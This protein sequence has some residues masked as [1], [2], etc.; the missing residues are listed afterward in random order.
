MSIALLLG[1]NKVEFFKVSRISLALFPIISFSVENFSTRI[2]ESRAVDDRRPEC[3]LSFSAF[4]III[5]WRRVFWKP[6]YTIPIASTIPTALGNAISLH[7]VDLAVS[8]PNVTWNDLIG[9]SPD[10]KSQKNNF[11]DDLDKPADIFILIKRHLFRSSTPSS[12]HAA[13][14]ELDADYPSGAS[15]HARSLEQLILYQ[16]SIQFTNL[17]FCFILPEQHDECIDA[18]IERLTIAF[19]SG[20]QSGRA[21]ADAERRH[22]FGPSVRTDTCFSYG[23]VLVKA[24]IQQGKLTVSHAG[25]LAVVST[26]QSLHA[27]MDLQIPT[28]LQDITLYTPMPDSADDNLSSP[29]TSPTAGCLSELLPIETHVYVKPFLAFY[30]GYNKADDDGTEL[31]ISSG[32]DAVGKMQSMWMYISSMRVYMIEKSLCEQQCIVEVHGMEFGIETHRGSE[33]KTSSRSS[34]QKTMT[35][36]IDIV[37]WPLHC[38]PSPSRSRRLSSDGN[39]ESGEASSGAFRAVE[40]AHVEQIVFQKHLQL[41]QDDNFIDTERQE[42]SIHK[43]NFQSCSQTLLQ[44]LCVSQ[45]LANCLPNSRFAHSKHS[46]MLVSIQT[47]IFSTMSKDDAAG[48]DKHMVVLLTGMS[49]LK[50]SEPFSED[51]DVTIESELLEI[52][53]HVDIARLQQ[54]HGISLQSKYPLEDGSGERCG[55]AIRLDQFSLHLLL[56]KALAMKKMTCADFKIDYINLSLRHDIIRSGSVKEPGGAS[57][58][59]ELSTGFNQ[60]KSLAATVVLGKRLRGIS[61]CGSVD[62]RWC[63]NRFNLMR[64]DGMKIEWPEVAKWRGPAGATLARSDNGSIMSVE[65]NSVVLNTST[66]GVVR[67]LAS[68]N[69]IT[70]VQEGMTALMARM[71][72][73]NTTA[74]DAEPVS[75]GTSVRIKKFETLYYV[76]T[77]MDDTEEEANNRSAKE[78][79]TASPAAPLPSNPTPA[80]RDSSANPQTVLH[81]LESVPHPLTSLKKQSYLASSGNYRLKVSHINATELFDTGNS[82]D[83]QDP[84]LKITVMLVTPANQKNPNSAT[85]KNVSNSSK[86]RDGVGAHSQVVDVLK[87]ERVVDAGTACSFKENFVVNILPKTT[88][89]AANS[90]MNDHEAL[91]SRKRPASFFGLLSPAVEAAQP[92]ADVEEIHLVIEARNEGWGKQIPIGYGLVRLAQGVDVDSSTTA[93]KGSVTL[94]SLTP[95]HPVKV[96]MNLFSKQPNEK[97]ARSTWGVLRGEVTMTLELSSDEVERRIDEVLSDEIVREMEEVHEP[98][99]EESESNESEG[100]KPDEQQGAQTLSNHQALVASFA[101]FHYFST[102]LVSSTRVLDES[103]KQSTLLQQ[104]SGFEWTK[105]SFSLDPKCTLK[106]TFVTLEDFSYVMSHYIS[107]L[108]CPAPSSGQQSTAARASSLPLERSVQL[109]GDSLSIS[110]SSLHIDISSHLRIGTAIRSLLNQNSAMLAAMNPKGN[111]TEQPALEQKQRY[112]GTIAIKSFAITSD[113]GIAGAGFGGIAPNQAFFSMQL[114]DISGSLDSRDEYSAAAAEIGIIDLG[115]GPAVASKIRSDASFDSADQLISYTSIMGGTAEAAFKSMT[116]EFAPLKEPFLRIVDGAISGPVYIAACGNPG[117]RTVSQ[118]FPLSESWIPTDSSAAEPP[119]YSF[120]ATVK[121][122]I[123]P[124]KVYAEVILSIESMNISTDSALSACLTAIQPALDAAQLPSPPTQI[125]QLNYWDNLRYW[126]HG[127]LVMTVSLLTVEARREFMPSIA[128]AE[129]RMHAP[130]EE[131][132]RRKRWTQKVTSSHNINRLAIPFN[133]LDRSASSRSDKGGA[134]P[135]DAAD[136]KTEVLLTLSLENTQFC[137]DNKHVEFCTSSITLDCLVDHLM[138]SEAPGAAGSTAYSSAP[139]IELEFKTETYSNP[140][141]STP[142]TAFNTQAQGISSGPKPAVRYQSARSRLFSLADMVYLAVRHNSAVRNKAAVTHHDVYLCDSA[143]KSSSIRSDGP[144]SAPTECDPFASFRLPEASVNWAIELA[145]G[146]PAKSLP[147]VPGST[148]MPMSVTSTFSSA[149]GP[150]PHKDANASLSDESKALHGSD[151]ATSGACIPIVLNC[152]LDL[153][154][155]IIL[156]FNAAGP[157]ISNSGAPAPQ[158]SSSSKSKAPEGPPGSSKQAASSSS[159]P[160]SV[161]D[162]IQTFDLQFIMQR[163]LISSWQGNESGVIV[164]KSNRR[165]AVRRNDLGNS[166]STMLDDYHRMVEVESGTVKR[167]GFVYELSSMDMQLRLV[168]PISSGL[169]MSGSDGANKDSTTVT[170][171]ISLKVDHLYAELQ[172]VS[173]HTR[174][175]SVFREQEKQQ[176]SAASSNDN[177]EVH[178]QQVDSKVSKERHDIETAHLSRAQSVNFLSRTP[179]G[180]RRRNEQFPLTPVLHGMGKSKYSAIDEMTNPLHPR[181]EEGHSDEESGNEIAN[182]LHSTASKQPKQPAHSTQSSIPATPVPLTKL[183]NG[184]LVSQGPDSLGHAP[185]Q[186]TARIKHPFNSYEKNR[187]PA[188]DAVLELRTFGAPSPSP[189]VDT[190]FV[191]SEA[192]TISELQGMYRP[193]SRLM[194]ASSLVVSLTEG[195]DVASRRSGSRGHSSSPGASFSGGNLGPNVTSAWEAIGKMKLALGKQGKSCRITRLSSDLEGLFVGLTLR[196]RAQAAVRAKEK[197]IREAS[198]NHFKHDKGKRKKRDKRYGS[199]SVNDDESVATGSPSPDSKQPPTSDGGVMNSPPDDAH[200]G[201]AHLHHQR[202]ESTRTERP[203]QH[204]GKADRLHVSRSALN[205]FNFALN[206]ARMEPPVSSLPPSHRSYH[207]QIGGRRR[208]NRSSLATINNYVGVSDDGNDNVDGS[209]IFGSAYGNKIWAMRMV[210]VQLLWTLDIRDVTFSYMFKYFELFGST[211][212]QRATAV[213]VSSD[214]G[215]LKDNLAEAAPSA[216]AVKETIPIA[217]TR[218]NLPLAS[219]SGGAQM[220]LHEVMPVDIH[221]PKPLLKNRSSTGSINPLT[222]SA[223]LA[224][225]DPRKNTEKSVKFASAIASEAPMQAASTTVRPRPVSS[226]HS[227]KKKRMTL[228][229]ASMASSRKNLAKVAIAQ[230]FFKVELVNPQINFYD[231]TDLHSSLSGVGAIGGS[232]LITAE[233]ATLEGRRM[234]TAVWPLSTGE[235]GGQSSRPAGSISTE[236]DANITATLAQ[237]RTEILYGM[238]NVSA[239][240]VHPWSHPHSSPGLTGAVLTEDEEVVWKVS[241]QEHEEMVAAVREARGLKAGSAIPSV[242][243]INLMPFQEARRHEDDLGGHANINVAG[244]GSSRRTS[245][246]HLSEDASLYRPCSSPSLYYLKEAIKDF[247]VQAQYSFFTDVDPNAKYAAA[248]FYEQAQAELQ[249]KFSLD[250]PDIRFDLDSPQFFIVASVTRNLLLAPPPK[251]SKKRRG[252]RSSTRDADVNPLLDKEFSADSEPAPS[253]DQ[254][255][256]GESLGEATEELEGE[257]G[258]DENDDEAEQEE[259][260]VEDDK[261]NKVPFD[262]EYLAEKGKTISLKD[263]RAI[264]NSGTF[265]LAVLDALKILTERELNLDIDKEVGMARAVEL[266]IGKGTW[267]LRGNA[268]EPIDDGSIGLGIFNSAPHAHSHAP[269]SSDKEHDQPAG[270]LETSFSGILASFTYHPDRKIETSFSVDR[271]DMRE[272]VGETMNHQA[273][274]LPHEEARWVIKSEVSNPS[275]C[276]NCHQPFD[277]DTALACSFHTNSDG[278]RGA[279]CPVSYRDENTGRSVTD[280]MWTCCGK[281][282]KNAGPCVSRHHEYKEKMLVVIAKANPTTRIDQIDV[283]VVTELDISFFEGADYKLT[284]NVSKKL[285]GLFYLYFFRTKDP[286]SKLAGTNSAVE[287]MRVPAASDIRFTVSGGAPEAGSNKKSSLS[288]R[289]QGLAPWKGLRRDKGDDFSSTFSNVALSGTYSAEFGGYGYRDIGDTGTARRDVSEALVPASQQHTHHPSFQQF[290]HHQH[291]HLHQPQQTYTSQQVAEKTHKTEPLK[292]AHAEALFIA[293][294]RMSKATININTEIPF[295]ITISAVIDPYTV[296]HSQVFTWRSLF[297]HLSYHV[298]SSIVKHWAMGTKSNIPARPQ[299]TLMSQNSLLVRA[300]NSVG[301]RLNTREN[302]A[303][304]ALSNTEDETHRQHMQELLGNYYNK[305]KKP[306]K[307]QKEDKKAK[308]VRNVPHSHR[309][310]KHAEASAISVTNSASSG[311]AARARTLSAQSD[312]SAGSSRKVLFSHADPISE[313]QALAVLAFEDGFNSGKELWERAL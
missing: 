305:A 102:T 133:K 95:N 170:K 65:L 112:Q 11:G 14:A 131:S 302:E 244:S 17:S 234:N 66:A 266:T 9:S 293:F 124:S 71:K 165:R 128:P 306:I 262:A 145:I 230:V 216:P 136:Y 56:G 287:L 79:S 21:D 115:K 78:G 33:G 297:E 290:Q 248:L 61:R 205:I 185:L 229:A 86:S 22:A 164:K 163:V 210:N 25:E 213:P 132:N 284:V 7:F 51:S 217:E 97:F 110:I 161:I 74:P 157:E 138:P 269:Q 46:K 243:T 251:Q 104:L 3:S 88:L 123:A 291:T 222:I 294:I 154:R 60:F 218:S 32:K 310:R 98:R 298:G 77:S 278:T 155:I 191:L 143:N 90:S 107:N 70:S 108:P 249:C 28:G 2:V 239:F 53:S 252:M 152:R 194:Y 192:R 268:E 285:Q 37:K 10:R 235:G 122:S 220:R 171:Q 279:Y 127:N 281:L 173:L 52:E 4:H 309:A 204:E 13:A 264:A 139:D 212:A 64:A 188:S 20:G 200:S 211:S 43:I 274:D 258:D 67:F 151:S 15:S 12:P 35:I 267:L 193:I 6:L 72:I 130:T 159:V 158:S 182:P 299:T 48:A 42:I 276:V 80:P 245:I 242:G 288:K 203:Q 76:Q 31:K 134:T 116:I 141:T 58:S 256:E 312:S 121:S 54:L 148:S 129:D 221:L 240:T 63:R 68:V 19:S 34:V 38:T 238:E 304:E 295:Y 265:S 184:P 178:V 50:S 69:I 202:L 236:A 272:V 75:S 255:L 180:K 153:L 259:L 94:T 125:P 275:P 214:A 111:S 92:K 270:S 282:N 247:Q 84:S 177:Q 144:E 241:T 166:F 105:A 150:Q 36:A 183:D 195:G 190:V 101:D 109:P 106:T 187:I 83:P 181:I 186:H 39:D 137:V 208:A 8:C 85:K 120:S 286:E 47:F 1:R 237:R 82:W 307:S 224:S 172:R 263:F 300:L 147:T 96:A 119:C 277:D 271:F 73:E 142:T 253:S 59:Q 41:S 233:K 81:R 207:N 29:S 149:Y 99:M 87:T 215:T 179:L 257:E 219:T 100:M 26:T 93:N 162:L 40:I 296:A 117:I 30:T 231:S 160:S 91:I 196:R 260:P 313:P 24:H 113:D 114:Q 289:L 103:T 283:S 197:T 62:I 250:L 232:V 44:W 168:R 135:L 228:T 311:V 254:R 189:G 198:A 227:H 45:D 89:D 246:L 49:V 140:W 5:D 156:A 301:L 223:P 225:A 118:D 175:W 273:A 169:P 303:R 201:H 280:Y 55:I 167:I 18:R 174:D 176:P 209:D 23:G 16:T 199:S 206:H 261:V 146:D 126:A 292:R 57:S 308:R 226:P 27:Q